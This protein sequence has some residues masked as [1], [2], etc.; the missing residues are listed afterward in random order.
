MIPKPITLLVGIPNL[1]KR[2]E[3]KTIP[4]PM[5]GCWLWTGALISG[6]RAKSSRPALRLTHGR[7]QSSKWNAT[8]IAYFVEY[9]LFDDALHVCHH[10]DNELCVNPRHLFLG[11]QLDNIRDRHNKGRTVL[12]WL[13]PGQ[14]HPNA[15]LTD[16]DVR[17]ICQL[18][19][20]GVTQRAIA[21]QFAIQQGSISAIA[22]GKTW[23]HI[24][25]VAK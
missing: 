24:S 11:T 2:L 8:R 21:K 5:S 13:L 25:G 23:R 10:C 9:G 1:A 14:R 18:L 7:W 3:Q 6:S 15:K 16:A 4:E 20:L 19:R 22:R 17:T 12:P